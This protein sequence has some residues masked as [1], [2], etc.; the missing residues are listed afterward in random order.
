MRQLLAHIPND[1]RVFF[2]ADSGFFNGALLDYL[3]KYGHAYL[4]KVKLG[5]FPK[6][7]TRPASVK[8]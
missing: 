1:V 3:E 8:I 7:D 4:I 6:Y 2:R 5:A